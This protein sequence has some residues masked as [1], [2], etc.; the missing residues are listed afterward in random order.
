MSGHRRGLV[1]RA[2]ARASRCLESESAKNLKAALRF[3]ELRR[4]AAGTARCVSDAEAAAAAA[5]ASRPR[6]G[7]GLA[8]S[9]LKTSNKYLRICFDII[10]PW[11]LRKI[12]AQPGPGPRQRQT[13]APGPSLAA[14]GSQAA[15]SL[16]IRHMPGDHDY[17]SQLRYLI[18]I[19][20][21]GPPGS[22]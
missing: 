12:L 20:T 17:P 1:G 14:P 4:P 22:S 16:R 11:R 13:Q 6:P 8:E 15:E 19:M 2:R 18:T 3:A 7:R 10:S 5:L 21:P 9:D